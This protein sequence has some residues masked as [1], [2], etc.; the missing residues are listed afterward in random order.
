LRVEGGMRLRFPEL[1]EE[2]Q[3]TPLEMARQSGGRIGVATVYRW[4]RLRG[5]VDRIDGA[6]VEVVC[7]L[8]GVG[9]TEVLELERQQPRRRG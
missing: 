2:H 4:Q 5:R 6:L 9:L 8:L 3:I 1:W 7:E